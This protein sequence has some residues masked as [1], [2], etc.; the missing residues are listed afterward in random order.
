VVV[1]EDVVDLIA[2]LAEARAQPL[3]GRG[4][5]FGSVTAFGRGF[6]VHEVGVDQPR[7]EVGLAA[8]QYA[9]Q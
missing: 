8:G 2:Q 1:G 4:R 6:V 5:A 9:R 7:N 3:T